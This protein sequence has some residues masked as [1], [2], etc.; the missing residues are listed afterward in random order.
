MFVWVVG[1]MHKL[2]WSMYVCVCVWVGEWLSAG[3]AQ[4]DIRPITYIEASQKGG[5]I[6]KKIVLSM[7]L[8]ELKF[9]EV[10]GNNICKY[11]N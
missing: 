11:F 10:F 2:A 6:E 1:K 7:I 9:F 5:K 8:W 4:T 3:Y